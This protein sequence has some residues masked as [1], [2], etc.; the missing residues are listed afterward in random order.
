MGL[1]PRSGPLGGSVV[2]AS[3]LGNDPG[4]DLSVA[5]LG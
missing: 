2:G 5:P 4:N 3:K 1:H